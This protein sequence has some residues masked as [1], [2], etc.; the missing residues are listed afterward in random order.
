MRTLTTE[1][2]KILNGFNP[3][4]IKN[5]FIQSTYTIHRKC[6][7]Q[8][9][10][11]ET[12]LTGPLH[13]ESWYSSQV[14]ISSRAEL[15]LGYMN[16]STRVKNKNISARAEIK[17]TICSK[18]NFMICKWKPLLNKSC[19]ILK[20]KRQKNMEKIVLALSSALTSFLLLLYILALKIMLVQSQL[21]ISL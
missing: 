19:Q 11:R 18:F 8:A 3:E 20:M 7:L 10:F 21:S 17:N 4:F 16:T 1:I 9:P 6:I 2:F 14:E 15:F 12:H 13:V 5:M